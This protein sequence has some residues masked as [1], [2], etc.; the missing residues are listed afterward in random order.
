MTPDRVR[1]KH[2]LMKATQTR[3]ASFFLAR[4]KKKFENFKLH[5]KSKN[6]MIIDQHSYQS[7]N[8]AKGEAE[9]VPR[10]KK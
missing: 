1:E 6:K 7:L 9:I 3:P 4:S 2:V 8:S 10:V 5:K